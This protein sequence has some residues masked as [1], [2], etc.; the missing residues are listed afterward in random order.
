LLGYEVVDDDDL[1]LS[2]LNNCGYTAE[3]VREMAGGAGGSPLCA[4]GKF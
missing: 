4:S 3:Q 2:I 1:F